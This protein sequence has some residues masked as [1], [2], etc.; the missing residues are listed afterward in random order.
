MKSNQYRQCTMHA[1][2]PDGSILRHVA[3]LPSEKAKLGK[4]VDIVDDGKEYKG[5]V[6]DFVGESVTI[7]DVDKVRENLKRFGWVLGK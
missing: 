5:F 6:I 3:Y 4:T 7:D 1:D 2:Q